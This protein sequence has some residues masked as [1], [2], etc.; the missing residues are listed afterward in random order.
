MHRGIY[1]LFLAAA[2]SAALVAGCGSSS[3]PTSSS[4]SSSTSSTPAAVH[5]SSTSSHAA[6][7]TSTPT[8]LG[9]LGA[10]AI[11]GYCESALAASK[12]HLSASQRSQFQSVCA[13]LAHDNPTQI[14]AAAKTLCQQI[15]KVVPAAEQALA[16]AECAKL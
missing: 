1:S 4:T 8:G 14:K 16:A 5:S 7:T 9:A 13:Q 10:A 6:K 2:A 15:T 11:S 3:T 12:T